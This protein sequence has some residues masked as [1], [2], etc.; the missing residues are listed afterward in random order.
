LVLYLPLPG[1]CLFLHL[2]LLN[3]RRFKKIL[4]WFFLSLLFLLV[5]VYIFIQTPLGQNWIA[6]Q[7]TKK[8]SRD[9]QT[10]VSI[11]HVNFALFNRMKLEGVLIEDRNQDTLLY[12]GTLNVRITDWFFL[13]NKAEL[14]YIGLEDAVVKFQRTDSGWRQQFFFDYFSSPSTGEKKKSSGIELDLKK[15]ELRNVTFI[16]KDAWL[17]QDMMVHVGSLDMDA[18]NLSLAGNTYDINSLIIKDPVFTQLNYPKLKPKDTTGVTTLTPEKIKDKID[19]MMVWNAGG[20]DVKIGT[21]KIENGIFKSDK[22]TDREAYSYFDGQHIFFSDIDADLSNAR[23][24]GD[25]IF[26][27]LKLTA[28]ERSGLEVKDLSADFK[29]MPQGMAFNNLNLQTNRSTIKNYFM[30]SYADMNDMGDFIHKVR[31]N[32]NFDGTYIDSDDIAFFAPNMQSWKKKITLKGKVRGTVDD[33]V[34]RDMLVQ[35]GTSTTLNGDIT[36]TGLP[37]I[38]QTFIDFKANDFRTTYIDATTIVPS[39]RRITNPDLR[40]LQYVQ[41]AGS[42]TGF[43]RD[44]VTYGTIRTNLGTVKSDLNMKLPAG[45]PPTYSGSVSTDNFQ[46]GQFLGD[47]MIGAVSLEGTVKGKGFTDKNRN[48]ELNG[49]IRYVDFNGYRYHNIEIEKGKLDKNQFDG[50]IAI[51]DENAELELKGLIDF[52]ADKPTFRLVA[53]VK[54]A[55]LQQLNL[56][57]DDVAFYGKFDL[58]FSGQSIDDFLGTAKITQASLTKDGTPLPFDSLELASSYKDGIKTITANSN[59]FKARISGEF[60]IEDLP[61]A[62]LTFLN[63][64]YPSYVNAPARRPDNE[65]FDFEISTQYVEDYLKLVDSSLKGFNYTEIAGRVD[66]R[67]DSLRLTVNTPYAKYKQYDFSNVNVTALGDAT[68]LDVTGSATNIYVNDSISMPLAEFRISSTNDVSKVSLSTRANQTLDSASLNAIVRTRPDGVDIEFDPSSFVL[69]GKK[70]TIDDNGT[71]HFRKNTPVSGELTL[72]EG[73]QRII[74]RTLAEGSGR[75]LQVTLEKLNLGDIAPFL[76]PKNRLEGLLSGTFKVEDPMGDLRITSNDLQTEYLRLDNDSLGALKAT[77]T[78]D[79]ASKNLKVN[80][81]TLNPD[82]FVAFNIDQ[83][84]DK[85][86]QNLSKIELDATEFHLSILDRFLGNLFSDIKGYI[87]GKFTINGPINN[88]TSIVGKG[89]LRDAGLKIDF[90]QCWYK[91]NDTEIDLR[92]NEINLDGIVLQDTLTKNP[93]YVEGSIEHSGF[94]D[95]FY[96]INVSTQQKNTRINKPVLLINTNYKDNQQFYGRVI[97]TGSFAL[98]GP[99]NQMF[100]QISAVASETDSSVVTIPSSTS[101]ASGMADFLIERKFGREMTDSLIKRD[102]SSVIY[103][104]DVTANKMVTVKVVLDDLTGDVI[105]GRGSGQLHIKSGTSEP[106]RIKGKYNILEGEYTFTFQSFFKKPFTLRKESANYI[107]WKENDDP[108]NATINFDAQYLAEKVSLSPLFNSLPGADNKL[109][110]TKTDVYVI[111]SLTGQL[112]RPSIKFKIDFPE[113]SVAKTDP[114]IS[115]PLQQMASDTS[116]IYKQVT[117]LIVFNSFAPVEGGGAGGGLDIVD[118][119][120]NTISGIASGVINNE[121]NK[122]LNKIL[123]NDKYSIN[124]NTSLYSRNI[125]DANRNAINIGTAVTF[126]IGRSFFNDRFIISAGGGFD[127]PFNQSDVAQSFQLLPNVTME[128]LINASGTI[129]A[130]FFYRQ[131]A[132]YLTTSA[133]GTNGRATR[134]GGN[135]SF[136]KEHNHFWEI[137]RGKNRN[138]KKKTPES[139]TGT[140]TDATLPQEEKKKESQGSN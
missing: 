107:E 66:M 51:R 53:D 62:F 64:Y 102:V 99:Q 38:N 41:F 115:F 94:K 7:V 80:G 56:T 127:A 29:L 114:S 54:K 47:P 74:V 90:T 12:A 117:Y 88:L 135:L 46:L 75:D 98:T 87:T 81:R 50:A 121:L 40:K 35:A 111:A 129:R 3:L 78:Y 36:L 84:L 132:D 34:G 14:K 37:D 65:A 17:G 28:K 71:L 109:A 125:I 68:R 118:I 112:F 6:K 22:Q 105:S 30:M 134:Y 138:N 61:D 77:L 108:M 113:Q 72:R 31:M 119:G 101:R 76:L 67:N 13:K 96:N 116:E 24:I 11:R 106:L 86:K 131:N 79:N 49:V 128:W 104:V 4:L 21:L 83:Y 39:I 85:D 122:I 19:S 137:F 58:D 18:N 100:M 16:K 10:R 97:G 82:H 26:S 92:P 133:N 44:F 110:G 45:Q 73:E 103:D 60:N 130:S 52:N 25:T 57:R 120:V 5:A 89:R 124:L 70:W 1:D 136:K 95:M 42:F 140:P 48:A 43:I 20:M 139:T 55:N 93:I 27:K 32:A 15:V 126:S 8:L 2:K 59:E 33:L 23:F 69:N 63:K 9:L 123:K 91:I